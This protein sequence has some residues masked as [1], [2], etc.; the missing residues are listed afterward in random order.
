MQREQFHDLLNRAALITSRTELIIFGSQAVHAVTNTPPVEVLVS[1]EC[2]F[3]IADDPEL[4]ARLSSELGKSS[5]YAVHTGIY[6]DLLP[7]QLPLLPKDWE[8]RLVPFVSDKVTA[9]CLEIHDLAVT[10]LAAGRLK[11]YEFI[12]AALIQKL[13]SADEIRRR[14]LSFA[15]PHTQ[16]VLLARLQI[17]AES[18]DVL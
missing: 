2:D 16:A 6:A 17:A 15:D 14:I 4:A 12:A 5:P 18:S 11:D 3:W 8:S 7:P 13:A 1:V 9:R 10:K